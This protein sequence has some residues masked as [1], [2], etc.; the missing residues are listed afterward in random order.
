LDFGVEIEGIVVCQQYD[1]VGRLQ[2]NDGGLDPHHAAVDI[3]LDD[4]GGRRLGPRPR[5]RRHWATTRT[6]DSRSSLAFFL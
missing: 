6:G 2:L 1:R 4:H 3:L 5:S